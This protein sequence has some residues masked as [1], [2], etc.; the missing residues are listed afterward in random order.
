MSHVQFTI[1]DAEILYAIPKLGA[2]V[3]T[4]VRCYMFLNRSAPPTQDEIQ[5][6]LTK[7]LNADI[8]RKFGDVF[9]VS[10]EWY[11]R[12]HAADE[13]ADNEIEAMLEF[14]DSVVNEEFT[15]VRRTSYAISERDFESIV[16]ALT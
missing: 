8:A 7:A 16:E 13:T 4:I 10:E 2:D 14:A 15:E 1:R 12:I 11:D 6:C 3:A 9:V 5:G